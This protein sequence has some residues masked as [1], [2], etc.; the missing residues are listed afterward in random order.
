MTG[1][2]DRRAT[3]DHSKPSPK[4]KVRQASTSVIASSLLG[5]IYK[6]KTVTP[7]AAEDI[8]RNERR[9]AGPVV[10]PIGSAREAKAAKKVARKMGKIK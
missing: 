6:N 7:N 1:W 10:K 3:A 4:G 9:K 5:D 2:Y 8:Q